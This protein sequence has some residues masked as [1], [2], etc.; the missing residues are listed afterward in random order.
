MGAVDAEELGRVEPFL[1][2][3]GVRQ[4]VESFQDVEAVEAG[5]LD[6]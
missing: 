5:H 2:V 1:Q 3:A 6:V 4:R